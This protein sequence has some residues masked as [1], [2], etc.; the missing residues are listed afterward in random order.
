MII[1]APL[2][3]AAK[4]GRSP[5]SGKRPVSAVVYRLPFPFAGIILIRY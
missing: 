2:K 4:K 5:E 3:F 1:Y